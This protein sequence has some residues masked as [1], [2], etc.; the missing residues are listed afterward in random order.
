MWLR[1]EP[2]PNWSRLLPKEIIPDALWLQVVRR[3]RELS[4]L[5]DLLKATHP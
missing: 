5:D 3:D 4:F 2:S 1:S